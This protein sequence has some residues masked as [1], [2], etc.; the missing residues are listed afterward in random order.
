MEFVT[1]LFVRK[2][3]AAS[4]MNQAT[5][6]ISVG[7][8]PDATVDPKAMVAAATY[9]EL[10]ERIAAQTNATELPLRTGASMRC[11][12]YG[13]LGLA[14]KAALTLRD[15][16]ARVERFARL[17]TSVVEYSL[18]RA[19]PDTWFRLY[20]SGPRRLGMRLSNEATLASA[21]CIGREVSSGAN[22]TPKEV[23]L[24]HPPPKDI[25]GHLSY[26]DCP[27]IF[28]SDRDAVLFSNTSLDLPNKL[29]DRGITKFLIGHLES[30]LAQ[31]TDQSRLKDRVRDLVA[32]TLSDGQPQ[33]KD[34]ARRL[35]MSS[36]SLHRRLSE[37]D[38]TFQALIESTRQ[39]IAKGMLAD[40]QY[41]LSEIAFLTGF[42][43]QSSFNRAFKR[44]VGE[45]PASF[46]KQFPVSGAH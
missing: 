25:R 19:G 45:T 33:M 29:G 28:N 42:A 27:V 7:L 44:W 13:A 30:E 6:L 36:R 15:S 4:T 21:V 10:L 20:R 2:M 9:Y 3:V 38:I 14:F 40:K 43:E 46:R 11:D 17:W 22:L 32:R 12:D 24:A 18:E 37:D 5:L 31:V 16:Y 26:F 34:I 8:D 41:S 1:S 39:D 23:H 35:G